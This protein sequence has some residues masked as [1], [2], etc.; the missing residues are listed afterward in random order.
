M[1]WNK[2]FSCGRQLLKVS[3]AKGKEKKCIPDIMGY[4][5]SH[6][7]TDRIV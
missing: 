5:L 1:R 2:S 6:L 4:R 3:F 7:V